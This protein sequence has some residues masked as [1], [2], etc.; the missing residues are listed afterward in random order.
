MRLI[1]SA[2]GG[3]HLLGRRARFEIA[4]KLDFHGTGAGC[5]IRVFDHDLSDP[6]TGA[7]GLDPF[8]IT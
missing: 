3:L 2:Q 1:V 6:L 7:I 5:K 4:G 8:L